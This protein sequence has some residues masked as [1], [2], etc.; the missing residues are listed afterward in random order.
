[1]DEEHRIRAVLAGENLKGGQ[2]P[3][4][5]KWQGAPEALF[6][7]ALETGMRLREM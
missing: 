4:D 5:L 6:D 3:L 2:R 1:M 7:L